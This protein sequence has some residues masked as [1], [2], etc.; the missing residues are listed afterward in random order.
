M[1]SIEKLDATIGTVCGLIVPVLMFDDREP[2]DKSMMSSATSN[3]F[4]FDLLLTPLPSSNAKG[5]PVDRE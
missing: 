2:F 5:I 4:A 3:W 1:L